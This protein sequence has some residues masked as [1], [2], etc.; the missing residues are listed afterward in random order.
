MSIAT[1]LGVEGN[2]IVLQEKF[3]SD[4]SILI[5]LSKSSSEAMESAEGKIFRCISKTAK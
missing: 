5:R 1:L 2:L 3:E 4:I